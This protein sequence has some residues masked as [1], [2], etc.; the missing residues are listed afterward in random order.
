MQR[1]H[2]E[3]RELL[4]HMFRI[5][6]S[7]DDLLKAFAVR[8]IVFMEEEGI[9][10][11]IE[12]DGHDCSAIHVL[13][14]EQGEPFAAGRIRPYNGYAKLE[15]ISV[16]KAYRGKNLGHKLTDFM[17][18]VANEKGFKKY[19][20]HAQSHLADFYRKHGFEISGDVF[21]EAGIDHYVMIRDDL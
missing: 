15:R 18:S 6:T 10:Y 7:L 8:S 19:L 20:L 11:T 14:E 12:H 9:P 16:R 5:A 21:Q 13:G 17:I 4:S 1:S 3:G 2:E